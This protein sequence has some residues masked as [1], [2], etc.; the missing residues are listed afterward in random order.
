MNTELLILWKKSSPE[1]NIYQK[2]NDMN[3]D[4]RRFFNG[5]KCVRILEWYIQHR[6]PVSYIPKLYHF[7]FIAFIGYDVIDF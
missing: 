1:K 4:W 6:P 2:F 7:K 3:T 5:P